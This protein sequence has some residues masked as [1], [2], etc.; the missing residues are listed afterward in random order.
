MQGAILDKYLSLGGPADG[1]LGF[2][3]I[4]EGDGKAPAAATPRSAPP[5]TR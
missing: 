4:D 5:T 3:T 1:D 2:P